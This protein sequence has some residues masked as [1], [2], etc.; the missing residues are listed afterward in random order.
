MPI[1]IIKIRV[2]LHLIFLHVSEVFLLKKKHMF[3]I[4]FVV[5]LTVH[6]SIFISVFNQLDEQNL[7]YNKFHF[8]PLY[9]SS[10]CAR[11]M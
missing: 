6:L 4:F 1:L 7:F 10:T 2:V 11:N 9:V 3:R 5:L 8:M